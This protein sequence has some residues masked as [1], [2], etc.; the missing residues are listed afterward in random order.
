[1]LF[2]GLHI[3]ISLWWFCLG[4]CCCCWWRWPPDNTIQFNWIQWIWW[5]FDGPMNQTF[6]FF[7]P[8]NSHFYVLYSHFFS[9]L[10]HHVV[11]MTMTT[12]RL[13][14]TNNKGF[15]SYD[16]PESAQN[17]I[18]SMNGFQVMNKRLKVQLKK[19]RE[20]PYWIIVI[21]VFF[22]QTTLQWE[23]KQ[24]KIENIFTH[25]QRQI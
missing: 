10:H 14:M 20:K 21:I 2:V 25:N 8:I 16:N 13:M 15:V 19:V 17:A 18:R 22:G 9:F 3:Y 23:K 12:W 6:P 1:M 5:C 24:Q 11:L 4:C 7:F